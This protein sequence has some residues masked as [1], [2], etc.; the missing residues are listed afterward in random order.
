MAREEPSDHILEFNFKENTTRQ[1]LLSNLFDSTL[2][3]GLVD[4]DW[5]GEEWL[6]QLVSLGEGDPPE[7]RIFVYN[8]TSKISRE[9][10]KQPFSTL[11]I[12]GWDS[13]IGRW[14]ASE[15]FCQ[16]RESSSGECEL[17]ILHFDGQELTRLP[18]NIPKIAGPPTVAV[19]AGSYLISTREHLYEIRY[20]Q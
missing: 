12:I 3:S 16:N 15:S 13:S 5:N 2:E 7:T 20:V 6:F 9:V 17:A 8:P 11:Q 1:V 14:V 4:V 10:Y 18:V 19:S